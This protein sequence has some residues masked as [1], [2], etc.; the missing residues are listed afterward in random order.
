M[1]NQA[2]KEYCRALLSLK[3]KDYAAASGHFQRAAQQFANDREF[4][5]LKETTDLLL[6]V[7][8]QR[9]QLDVEDKIEV[10]EVIPYGQETKLR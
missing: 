9:A 3:D 4:S 6:V 2:E 5:L 10:E 8:Q 7:R 1:L